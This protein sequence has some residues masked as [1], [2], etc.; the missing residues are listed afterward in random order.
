MYYKPVKVKIT[1]AK[2]QAAAAVVIPVTLG[3]LLRFINFGKMVIFYGDSSRDFL[4]TYKIIKFHEIVW[5]GPAASVT[6]NLLSPIYYY[7]LLPFYLI[8]SWHPLT[9][10][11][12]TAALGVLTIILI[13]FSVGDLFG[14]KAGFIAA[15]IYAVGSVIIPENLI[16]LNPGLTPP[17]TVLFI[18]S[19]IKLLSGKEKYFL[20]LMASLA[21]MISFHASSF[22]IVPAL[23][24][25]LAI[26]RPRISKRNLLLG[27]FLF[28]VLAVVPYGIQEKKFGGYNLITVYN[29]F[30]SRDITAKSLIEY[31]PLQTSLINYSQIIFKTPAE[32]LFPTGSKLTYINSVFIWTLFF[33]FLFRK[34]KSLPAEV[35]WLLSTLALY[36]L[37]FGIGVR[38]HSPER[39]NWWFGNVFFPLLTMVA[40]YF[41]AQIKPKVLLTLV[42]LTVVVTNGWALRS[43][44]ESDVFGQYDEEKK[45]ALTVLSDAN[46]DNFDFKYIYNNLEE[47]GSTGP[48]AYLFW[49]FGQPRFQEKYFAWLNWGTAPSTTNTYIVFQNSDPNKWLK[50]NYSLISKT[51]GYEI[52][53]LVT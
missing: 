33:V 34:R 3:T 19:L 31:V 29:Y 47:A 49:Y 53:K 38:F 45:I 9:Q 17:A 11:V 16:G 52:Y 10:Q 51:P 44:Q 25:I 12:L 20:I 7:L 6:W 39:P 50:G 15:L 37:I 46:L 26:K 27:C 32:V 30:F 48:F 42:L 21:W 23:I 40:G 36:S 22:F 41:L 13:F 8:S 35:I 43:Y 4:T 24:I 1:K 28:F 14:K 18:W 5:H 2:V